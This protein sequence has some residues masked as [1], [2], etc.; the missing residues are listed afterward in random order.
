MLLGED[1][2][3]HQEH[4]L[5][6]VV[7]GLERRAERDLGLAVAHVAADQ[8]VH[9]ARLLHVGLDLLDRLEL[10]GRLLVGEGA[11]EVHQPLRVGGERV[12]RAALALGV[13]VDQLAR[14]R[15]GGAAGAQLLLLPLLAAELRERRVAGVG[16]HVAGDLVELV[17][18]HEHAVAVAVLELEVVARHAP[19]GL[20]LEARE[21]RDAVVL[22]HDG[23]ARAQVGELGD[24]AAAGRG[25]AGARRGGGAAAGARA[26]SRASGSGARKPSRRLAAANV[27]P[28]SCGAGWPFRKP[29]RSRARL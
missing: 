9:R 11:L 14:Q 4:D 17:A 22:V 5:L 20:G 6:A 10:V 3:G 18:R 2:G 13:E 21:A 16:P 25:P 19:D 7:R 28:G 1:R 23:V 24:G 15:L 12:A 26:G 29:A 8:A 27:T